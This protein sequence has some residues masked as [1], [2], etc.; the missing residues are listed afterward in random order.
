MVEIKPCNDETFSGAYLEE[1]TSGDSVAVYYLGA[2]NDISELPDNYPGITDGICYKDN[3]AG[4]SYYITEES[5]GL[6]KDLVGPVVYEG[7][8]SS[9]D[10]AEDVGTFILKKLPAS[11]LGGDKADIGKF[12]DV[13][14]AIDKG[15]DPT[16]W[17][18]LDTLL[19]D[20]IRNWIRWRL[21]DKGNELFRSADR[22]GIYYIAMDKVML[23]RVE[24]ELLIVKNAVGRSGKK[25]RKEFAA[26]FNTLINKVRHV[27]GEVERAERSNI[28]ERF[29][30][31]QG[32]GFAVGGAIVALVFMIGK[33]APQAIKGAVRYFV[34][35]IK[36]FI[37]RWPRGK[38]G[39]GSGRSVV[40]G[41]NPKINLRP[42]WRF[43]TRREMPLEKTL[44]D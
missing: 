18:V 34:E 1:L 3:G 6:L 12:T 16:K 42:G 23:Q 19:P 40:T 29:A 22:A 7:S 32:L 15:Y 21:E 13:P 25:D 31:P 37:D 33:K 27:R 35:V 11:I 36:D 26:A 9:I 41:P 28:W 38:G 17:Q 8:A 14:P 10:N 24:N 44:A 30:L 2:V 43:M 20:N 4:K 39:G 5:R